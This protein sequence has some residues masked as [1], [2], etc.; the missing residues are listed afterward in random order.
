MQDTQAFAPYYKTAD[1]V[2]SQTGTLY[3]SVTV[4]A[5]NSA[6][7]ASAVIPGAGNSAA[8]QMQIANK[9]SAWAHVN[10]GI[11]L[12]GQTVTAATVASSYPVGPGAVVIVTV[13]PEVNAASVILDAA[14]TGS[15]SVIFTR[16]GGV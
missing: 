4:A 11:L 16:G 7:T 14:P 1:P 8:N 15:T 5:S 13:A 10:F 12:G 9:T 6:A 2:N 3:P